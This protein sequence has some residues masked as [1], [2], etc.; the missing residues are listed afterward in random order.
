ME[1]VSKV[2]LW[3]LNGVTLNDNLAICDAVWHSGR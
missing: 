1:A 3:Q 2:V